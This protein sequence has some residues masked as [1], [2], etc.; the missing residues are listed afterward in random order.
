M[1]QETTVLNVTTNLVIIINVQTNPGPGHSYSLK[2]N[3][4]KH[5]YYVEM[6]GPS[7]LKLSDVSSTSRLID[8]LLCELSEFCSAYKVFV[9]M[10]MQSLKDRPIKCNNGSLE[11]STEV[12]GLGSYEEM[13]F[14]G[15]KADLERRGIN[16]ISQISDCVKPKKSENWL[17]TYLRETDTDNLTVE[18]LLKLLNDPM[19][20]EHY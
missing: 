5:N 2:L 8:T 15:L 1:Q 12:F 6:S 4:G 13:Y 18:K 3:T 9:R 20:K 11:I 16:A 17:Q 10:V 19:I 14:S 7:G